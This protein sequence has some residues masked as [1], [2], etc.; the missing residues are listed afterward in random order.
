MSADP[1]L[2]LQV[3]VYEALKLFA[4]GNVFAEVPAGTPLPFIV[5]GD[6]FIA[7]EYD[8]GDWSRCTVNVSVFARNSTELKTLAA[9]VRAALDLPLSVAGF[10]T[11]EAYFDDIQYLKERDGKARHAAMSFEYVLI[12]CGD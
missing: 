10:T 6:D 5:Y 3:A 2:P 4:S 7:A 12:P 1:S 9:Q 11:G 8:S